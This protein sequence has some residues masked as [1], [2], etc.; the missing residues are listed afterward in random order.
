MR[1]LHTRM[2]PRRPN[3]VDQN[4]DQS[5][6]PRRLER[7]DSTPRHHEINGDPV[8]RILIVEDELELAETLRRILQRN[9][10]IVDLVSTVGD[11]IGSL[12]SVE[13]DLLILDR[14]LPD[15]D[16]LSVLRD[17]DAFLPPTLVLSALSQLDDRVTGLD[18]GADDYLVKPFEPEELLARLRA[19]I[20]RPPPA[21]EDSI[22][23]GNLTFETTQRVFSVED[24]V[25]DLPRR[26]LNILEKLILNSGRVV[27]RENLIE[28]VYGCDDR[29]KSN[30]M[31][32]QISK[33]RSRLKST[34]TTVIIHA[35]RGLGYL[36]R[37]AREL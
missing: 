24:R 37:P 28:A 11:A 12:R 15:G 10:Y 22:R 25:L 17:S 4:N 5:G 14:C 29:I 21:R 36:I 23:V 33:L 3:L 6:F 18:A 31:E 13:Y 35:A 20:R 27:L 2:Q 16:G 9:R 30:T 8:L 34:G 32:A 26:Q 7:L 1:D 19:L